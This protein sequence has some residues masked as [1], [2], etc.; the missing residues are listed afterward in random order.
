MSNRLPTPGSDANDWGTILNDFLGVSLNSD[1]TLQTSAVTTAGGEV[2]SNKG[3]ANGYAPLNGNG[4][5][6]TANLGSSNASNTTFLRGDSTWATLTLTGSAGGDLAG[7]YPNPTLADTTN[8]QS[9]IADNIPSAT[10]TTSGIVKQTV[11][12]VRDYG[13]TGDGST[14]DTAAINSAITAAAVNG[15]TVYLP[16][17]TYHCTGNINVASGI[18]L[19]GDGYGSVILS[20]PTAGLEINGVNNVTVRNL[21]VDG[22]DSTG[23]FQVSIYNSTNVLIDNIYGT[24]LKYGGIWTTA[25]TVTSGITIRDCHL[26][27]LGQA[28]IIGGGADNSTGAIVEE[29]NVDGNFL[30]QDA[31]QGDGY[32]NAIDMVG[33]YRVRFVNNTTYGGIVFGSEQSPH[34]HSS[35]IGNIVKPANSASSGGI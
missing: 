1:G 35:I 7:T 4:I 10:F 32:T 17:G 24:N 9:I 6:P 2:T 21:R 3:V 33:V 16:A 34:R 26:Y 19:Y 27:G 29:V 18:C 12:N 31:S 22:S 11:Y 23:G 8:V 13:A 30:Y 25:T 5:V 28:D 20:G 15:G 14:N